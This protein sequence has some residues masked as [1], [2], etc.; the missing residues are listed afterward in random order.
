M[1][2]RSKILEGVD[3]EREFKLVTSRGNFEAFLLKKPGE[4]LSA[5]VKTKIF[6]EFYLVA[7]SAFGKKKSPQFNLDVSNHLFNVGFLVLVFDFENGGKGVAFRTFTFLDH[8]QSKILYIEGTAIKAEYQGSGIYQSLTKEL[9]VGMDFVVSRTQNPVVITALSK[10]YKE[11]YPVT[12]EPDETIKNIGFCVA[13]YLKM[14]EYERDLMI[15]RKTYGGILNGTLPDTGN[16]M[17]KAV[18]N[19]IDPYNGD[20]LI[21]VC[22]V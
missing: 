9:A 6:N 20:C 2:N 15:G 16:G 13:E 21:A 4:N 11:V 5:E 12:A 7:L 3:C 17:R 19:L 10:L 22:P 1:L 18:T 14:S 8:K